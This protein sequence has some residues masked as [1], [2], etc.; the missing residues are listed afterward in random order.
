[1]IDK[2]NQKITSNLPSQIR[3]IHLFVLSLYHKTAIYMIF[4]F[5]FL[6]SQGTY[7]QG[8]GFSSYITHYFE[9]FCKMPLIL[10]YIVKTS[11][12]LCQGNMQFFSCPYQSLDTCIVKNNNS[13]KV[14]ININS[15]LKPGKEHWMIYKVSFIF[16]QKLS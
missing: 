4:T 14:F 12:A 16:C 9:L 6:S 2:L 13:L 7:K 8:I 3:L 11:P 5:V 10:Y 1:M 15:T